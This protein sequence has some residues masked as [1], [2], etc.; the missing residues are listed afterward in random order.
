ME[1]LEEYV[2]NSY[3]GVQIP[4]K[5]SG[6]TTSDV[7]THKALALKN[8]LRRKEMKKAKAHMVKVTKD[9]AFGDGSYYTLRSVHGIED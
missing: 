1:D 8:K 4:S 5:E 7:E 9:L 6:I 3:K 2:T